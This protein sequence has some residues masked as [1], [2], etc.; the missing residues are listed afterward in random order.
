MTQIKFQYAA[1]ACA[2]LLL[3]VATPARADW[4]SDRLGQ[5]GKGADKVLEA[6]LKLT[7]WSFREDSDGDFQVIFDKHTVVVDSHVQ[8]LMFEK[9]RAVWVRL[10]SANKQVTGEQALDLLKLNSKY[11][12]G[13]WQVTCNRLDTECVPVFQIE[14]PADAN[15]R[16]LDMAI[17]TAKMAA[18]AVLKEWTP[19][20][21]ITKFSEL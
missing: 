12:I 5:P 4:L 13:A 15:H 2:L 14:L 16:Y 18:D 9:I 11:K 21:W 19:K 1:L 3:S 7:G 8:Q 17:T 20:G 6:Q 10:H